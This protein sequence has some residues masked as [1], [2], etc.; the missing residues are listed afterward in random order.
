MSAFVFAGSMQFVA[1]SL[2]TIKV[3]PVTALL[4]TFLVNAGTSLRIVVLGT[5]RTQA[6]SDRI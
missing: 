2:L 4:M 3:M 6:R 5:T 1:V